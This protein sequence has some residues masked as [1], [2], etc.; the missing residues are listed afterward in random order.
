[1]KRVVAVPSPP[2]PAAYWRRRPL[3]RSSSSTAASPEPYTYGGGTGLGD[4]T[5]RGLGVRVFR[6]AVAVVIG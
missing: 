3:E 4:H 1:M 6:A 2:W 5:G